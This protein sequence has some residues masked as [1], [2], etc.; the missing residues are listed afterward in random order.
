MTDFDL[1]IK[2]ARIDDDKDLVDIGISG[3][4]ISKIDKKLSAANDR[5]GL[6]IKSASGF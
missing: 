2:R 1:V 4:K 6:S 3:G 5:L